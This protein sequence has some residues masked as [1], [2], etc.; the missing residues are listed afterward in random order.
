[1]RLYMCVFALC[2]LYLLMRVRSPHMD[3][4]INELSST[5]PSTM[6][7]LEGTAVIIMQ[8]RLHSPALTDCTI[9]LITAA[10]E[11]QRKRANTRK[12]KNYVQSHLYLSAMK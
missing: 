9:A 8:L 1:M 7:S 6:S 4:L 12:R 10:A 5:V 11:R 3:E 2:L